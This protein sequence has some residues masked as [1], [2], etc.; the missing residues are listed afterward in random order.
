MWL[1]YTDSVAYR[2]YINTKNYN[3]IYYFFNVWMMNQ[4][5]I[6]MQSV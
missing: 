6:F 1:Y 5:I 4:Q 2:S 3:F